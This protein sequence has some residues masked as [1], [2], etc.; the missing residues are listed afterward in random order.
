MQ[1]NFNASIYG[2][3]AV[4]GDAR[5]TLC[6]ITVLDHKT[7]Y[8]DCTPETLVHSHSYYELH[9]ITSGTAFFRISGKEVRI[10][11][12]NLLIIG[13][14]VLHQPYMPIGTDSHEIVLCL[15]LT[16]IEGSVG[17]YNYFKSSLETLGESPLVL[18]PQLLHRFVSFFGLFDS[19][20]FRDRC[21]QTLIAHE[22]VVSLFEQMNGF[23][24]MIDEYKP[25]HSQYEQQMLLEV[26]VN[27]S[28]YTMTEI[29]QN[30]GYSERHTARLIKQTYGKTLSEIRNERK[31][32]E[33]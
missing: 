2:V 24:G 28:I 5:F 27:G 6:R 30:L 26:L 10:G 14:N 12:G 23:S 20:R 7:E 1:Q 13:P 9:V 15:E 4:F 18:P 29:A 31:S 3:N 33:P 16:Q 22:I 25:E 32:N 17:Y 8:K 11:C 21:L 19:A